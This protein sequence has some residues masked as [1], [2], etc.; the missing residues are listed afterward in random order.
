M[1]VR[2]SDCNLGRLIAITREIYDAGSHFRE[3]SATCQLTLFAV[4]KA[5]EASAF[6]CDLKLLKWAVP[7]GWGAHTASLITEGVCLGGNGQACC[8]QIILSEKALNA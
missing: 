6:N 4:V 3:A 8:I 7:P 5:L 1:I 2:C